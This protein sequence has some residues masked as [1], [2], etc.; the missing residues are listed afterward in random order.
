MRDSERGGERKNQPQERER[1]GDRHCDAREMIAPERHVV[2]ERERW[3]EGK[4]GRGEEEKGERG[5]D[6]ERG[7]AGERATSEES[8][9]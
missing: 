8:T 2:G 9:L 4:T 7:R 5:E 6:G 3:E 1:P